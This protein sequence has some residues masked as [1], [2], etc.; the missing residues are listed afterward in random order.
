MIRH[1]A[2]VLLWY[3]K[4]L[5]VGGMSAPPLIARESGKD[6]DRLIK[7]EAPKL[8]IIQNANIIDQGFHL[9]LRRLSVI[10]ELKH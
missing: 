5:S 7:C 3:S 9:G 8:G 6:L 10:K 1:I 2:I 4:S